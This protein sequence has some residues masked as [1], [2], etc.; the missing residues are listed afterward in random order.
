MDKKNLMSQ[1]APPI[2]QLTM[3]DLSSE[4]VELSEEILSEVRG[5]GGKNLDHLNNVDNLA[6]L[7]PLGEVRYIIWSSPHPG[8]PKSPS[9]VRTP[10]AI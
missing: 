6:V 7:Q 8:I 2:N 3:Q 10:H 9:P 5:G 4:L 1:A